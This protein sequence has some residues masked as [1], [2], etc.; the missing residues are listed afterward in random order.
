MHELQIGDIAPNFSAPNCDGIEISLS[1]FLGKTILLYFYP[2]DNTPGCTIQAKDFS[3]LKEDFEALGCVILGISPDTPKSHKSFICKQNLSIT[4]LS[5]PDK[6]I[7]TS[8]GAYGKK[9]LYGKEV[10]GIKRSSFLIDANAKIAKTYYNVKAKDHA[11][12]VLQDLRAKTSQ[13]KAQAQ[14]KI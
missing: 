8:Y 1:D 7:A 5:D 11:Q 14:T 10:M 9:L 13:A 3:L 2:K 12:K 6:K 4:L